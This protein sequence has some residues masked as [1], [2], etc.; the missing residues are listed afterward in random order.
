MLAQSRRRAVAKY[1]L[2]AVSRAEDGTVSNI[3]D[4]W[5]LTSVSIEDAKAEADRQ[6]W[7]QSRELANAFEIV[8][9]SGRVLAWR[10]FRTEGKDVTW[11]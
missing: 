9:A 1:T 7:F 6:K 2:R 3:A 5:P 11:S 4:S 8:D 10:P